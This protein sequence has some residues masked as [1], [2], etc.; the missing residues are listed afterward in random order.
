MIVNN[1]CAD[2]L[3]MQ[4][5]LDRSVMTAGFKEMFSQLQLRRL[6][7]Q[8]SNHYAIV[9]QLSQHQEVSQR[10]HNFQISENVY[11]CS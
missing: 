2:E 1:G 11:K 4:E 3:N 9:L 5:R 6:V 8:K 7:R 10:R